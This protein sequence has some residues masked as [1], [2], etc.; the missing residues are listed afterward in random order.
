MTTFGDCGQYQFDHLSPDRTYFVSMIANQQTM[1]ST[2][3][4]FRTDGGWTS[5]SAWNCGNCS[6]SE[7]LTRTRVCTGK[8]CTGPSAQTATTSKEK[9]AACPV[10]KCTTQTTEAA[11]VLVK[12]NL[13]SICSWNPATKRCIYGQLPPPPSPTSPTA[14]SQGPKTRGPTEP[15]PP[16]PPQPP[17][18]SGKY[19]A[20]F[21]QVGC[22]D[23]HG[24][25]WNSFREI[26]EP[27]TPPSPLPPQVPQPKG[28]DGH[29]ELMPNPPEV[30]TA[31]AFQKFYHHW[32][33]W[34]AVGGAAVVLILFISIAT[35]ASTCRGRSG[36]TLNSPLLQQQRMSRPSAPRPPPTNPDWNHMN[37][38]V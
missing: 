18:P 7:K 25:T 9:D 11:C 23:H 17:Q 19:C 15:Q 32:W 14:P 21:S 28:S 33:F 4:T 8:S 27:G 10:C 35:Y 24:C 22:A 16:P 36:S 3:F 31:N 34:P 13:K 29:G 30:P 6:Y 1:L 38:F 37:T 2:T 12:L 26:C 20:L 5:W